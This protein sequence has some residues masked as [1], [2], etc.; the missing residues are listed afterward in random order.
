MKWEG[1]GQ[2]LVQDPEAENVI[3]IEETVEET[4]EIEVTKIETEEKRG[5]KIDRETERRNQSK[6]KVKCMVLDT[7]MSKKKT[8]KRR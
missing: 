6:M 8:I 7:M 2:D 1:Q 4:T 3:V 5:T